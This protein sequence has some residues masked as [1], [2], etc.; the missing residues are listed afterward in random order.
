MHEILEARCIACGFTLK[1]LGEDRA[2]ACRMCGLPMTTRA[3]LSI[4]RHLP[5]GMGLL[6]GAFAASFDASPLL[7]PEQPAIPGFA[8]ST[9]GRVR[10]SERRRALATFALPDAAAIEG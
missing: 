6:M 8:R 10:E 1:G 3:N 9:A 5:A 7:A 4:S 2:R